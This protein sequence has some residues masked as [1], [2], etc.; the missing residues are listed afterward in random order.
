MF[1]HKTLCR[2]LG[3]LGRFL[4]S[5]WAGMTGLS[6]FAALW[7][8]GSEQYGDFILPAPLD[9]VL[10]G[11]ALAIDPV[12]WVLI[13]TTFLRAADGFVLA[14][15]AGV[16]GGLIAGYSPA[17]MRL[18]RPILTIQLGVPPIAWMVL[19]M[20]WFGS[21][22]GTVIITIAVACFPLVFVNTA[23]GVITRDRGLDDMAKV[24]GA[25]FWA[26]LY[27]TGLRH[28]AAFLFPALTVSLGSAIK[29]GIMAEL[30]SNVG[31]IGGA[32]AM[33]RANLDVAAALAWILLAVAGL[34]VIEYLLLHPVQANL[35]RWRR[36]SPVRGGVGG[37]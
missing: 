17:A 34:I 1:F 18:F 22:S 16:F 12:N 30:L 37:R 3:G 6:L 4:W 21:G 5:G 19:A 7:Q 20:I 10:V 29:I 36:S 27:T 9:V 33:A 28:V 32:L 8:A 24:F 13:G 31:G 11:Y 35:D 14:V 26:R 25:G 15:A 2:K 23:E